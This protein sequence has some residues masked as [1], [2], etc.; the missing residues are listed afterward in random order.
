[1]AHVSW[2]E[3]REGELFFVEAESTAAGW[4]FSE[5][6]TN[7][8][9]WYK[10]RPKGDWIEKAEGIVAAQYTA[11]RAQ[12]S[13]QPAGSQI[14]LGNYCDN[15]SAL[16]VALWKINRGDTEQGLSM[17]N[18]LRAHI[19]V[20]SEEKSRRLLLPAVEEAIKNLGDHPNPAIRDHLKTGQ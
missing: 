11:D 5:R 9:C 20:I 19:L 10:V 17:L 13:R 3:N 18:Q 7:E 16:A 2:R 15:A 12:G 8:V 1:M 4:E 14:E 6:S